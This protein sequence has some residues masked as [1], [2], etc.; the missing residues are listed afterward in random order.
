MCRCLV[1]ILACFSGF[2]PDPAQ[3]L[4]GSLR[5]LPRARRRRK[6]RTCLARRRPPAR[7]RSRIPGRPAPPRRTRNRDAGHRP[8]GDRGRAAPRC[9]PPTSSDCAPI[10]G[11]AAP[12]PAGRGPELFRGKGKCLDCHRVNGEGNRLRSRPQRHR[13][14]ARSRMAAPRPDAN[15]KPRSSTAS[16]AIAGP[17]RS[18]TI[19]CWSKSPRPGG[20][21]IAGSR[22]NED[23]F[24]IQIRDA[25]GR[26]RSFLKSELTAAAQAVG[27][28]ADAVVQR[29]PFPRGTGR[30]R[31]LP[32]EPAGAP[33][34]VRA[35]LLAAVAVGLAQVSPERIRNADREPGNWL[36]YSRTFNGHRFTP[37]DQITTANA[38]RLAGRVDVSD[39]TAR[40]VLDL[41]DRHRRSPLHHRTGRRS[42][43][44]RRAHRPSR[45]AL[46]TPSTAR[47]AR[48]A[49]A[50]PTAG[51]PCSTTCCSSA[52]STRTCSRST[53]KPASCAGTPWS[54]TIAPATPSRLRRWP[55]AT[56]WSSE[57]RAANS[58][59]A[60]SSTPTTPRPAAACGASG[61]SP[62]R[63][64]R[65]TNRG[66]ARV[67]RPAARPR[68]SPART[69]PPSIW[70]IGAPAIPDP[71]TTA[72]NA[73]ATISIPVRWSRWMATPASCAGTFNSRRTTSTIGIRRTCRCWSMQADESSFVVANR[74]GFYY[75]LDRVTGEFL[76]GVPF[77]KQT[78][79]SGLDAKGRPIR[80]AR[81]PNPLPKAAWSIPAST[82]SPTGSARVSVR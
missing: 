18:P 44:H 3:P 62:D 76:R 82:A 78:W 29:R 77:G 30:D 69:I 17:F 15:R 73:R 32:D 39:P 60:D 66:R 36:T 58:V 20:E 33:M 55:S 56:R 8:A 22:L 35:M 13:P 41:A 5:R 42:R 27:Q 53:C 14:S 50:P 31:H 4:P 25:A 37:L 75:V 45:V 7:Q 34:T 19:T 21:R 52:R 47:P 16:P 74:N 54:P 48:R 64:S 40:Q 46:R 63:A 28:V 43:G 23:A 70:S 2:G 1:A 71:T 38:G 10:A 68:G 57:S 59:F 9:S 72:T 80:L 67:G 12:T 49:A 6:P 81:T 11:D 61:P 79:A 26:I 51:S 65:D 24:S